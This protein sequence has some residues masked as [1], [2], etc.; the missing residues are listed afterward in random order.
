MAAYS[1]YV[2][3]SYITQVNSSVV[4]L[5]VQIG[6]SPYLISGLL[7]G[8]YYYVV[9]AFN[10][11][12]NTSSNCIQVIVSGIVDEVI[13][14]GY[15]LFTLIGIIFIFSVIIIQRQLRHKNKR[16][17]THIFFLCFFLCSK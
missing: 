14:P 3:N 7:D 11:Y 13:I 17:K 5:E 6:N 1:I 10:E 12:G 4:L 9:V 15:N 8:T 16:S 2:Y